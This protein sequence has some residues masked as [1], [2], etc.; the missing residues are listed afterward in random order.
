MRKCVGVKGPWLVLGALLA[1]AG[2]GGSDDD[3]G[4]NVA[5][6]TGGSAATG[7]TSSGGTAATGGNSSGGMAVT[8][9]TTESGGNA[10]T[11]GTGGDPAD[12]FDS[13]NPERNAVTAGDICDRLATLQCAGEQNCCDDPGR[14]FDTCKSE[15]LASCR[16]DTFLDTISDDPITGFNEG[17]ARAAM[18]EFENKAKDCDVTVA[19][20]GESVEGLRGIMEGTR[21]EGA[22]CAGPDNGTKADAAA[23]LASCLDPE[24]VACLVEVTIVPPSATATCKARSAA[25]GKCLTDI[26]CEKGL[27]CPQSNYLSPAPSNCEARIALDGSC[28]SNNECESLAC[29]GGK[30]VEATANSAYCLN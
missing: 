22:S 23:A 18:L 12:Y 29:K 17:L 10:Q 1:L 7:G 21:D 14:D 15:A 5:T 11:G 27:Y 25:G 20:W 9:G 2:C 8:G 13:D 28:K 30:C 6:M 19:S 4:D 16:N 26:N 3:G 24:N